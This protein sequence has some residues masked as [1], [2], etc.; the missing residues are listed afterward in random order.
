MTPNIESTIKRRAAQIAWEM[1]RNA[2]HE[3]AGLMLR[4]SLVFDK[5]DPTPAFWLADGASKV[6]LNTASAGLAIAWVYTA[7]AM[8]DRK[9]RGDVAGEYQY[10]RDVIGGGWPEVV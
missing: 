8:L 5:T 6:A 10:A 3:S 9:N 4:A 1:A 7:S 2:D